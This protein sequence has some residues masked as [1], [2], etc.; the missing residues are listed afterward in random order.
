MVTNARRAAAGEQASRV[1]AGG[2]ML[3]SGVS[4]LRTLAIIAA[5]NPPLL[6]VTAAPLLAAAAVCA[7]AAFMLADPG[8]PDE[9]E[10]KVELRNPFDLRSVLSFALLLGIITVVA[11]VLSERYGAAGAL[12]TAVTTGLA[13]VDAVTVSISGLAPR[14]LAVTTAGYAILA[15]V[16]SN[17]VAK[18]LL[19][20]AGGRGWFAVHV[21]AMTA[22]ALLA[23]GAGL[24]LPMALAPGD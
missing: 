2:A 24:L 7:I 20:A 3:A 5:L 16:A 6:G 19:G 1:L 4:M 9:G 17:M 8:A 14:T 22:L 10:R 21:A 12:V 18:L 11:R 15:A 23:A 13:D